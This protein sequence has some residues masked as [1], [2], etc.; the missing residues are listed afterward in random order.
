M[1]IYLKK[2][3]NKILRKIHSNENK[4]GLSKIDK[5]AINSIEV[6]IMLYDS[7]R[8]INTEVVLKFQNSGNVK[9]ILENIKINLSLG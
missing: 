6:T 3:I 1:T 5:S 8:F 4:S 9:N 2:K 7:I